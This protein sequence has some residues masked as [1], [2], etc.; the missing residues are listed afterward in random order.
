MALLPLL[1]L[2]LSLPPSSFGFP[3]CSERMDASEGQ[4]TLTGRDAFGSNL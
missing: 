4:E 3:K 1:S 2:L